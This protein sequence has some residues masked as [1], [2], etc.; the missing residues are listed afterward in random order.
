[1][2]K[3]AWSLSVLGA[4][5]ILS[6]ALYPFGVITKNLFLILIFSGAGIMFV[7]SMIRSLVIWR[8]K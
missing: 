6:S 4:L 7:G 3:V 5:L 2:G 1:M 8:K